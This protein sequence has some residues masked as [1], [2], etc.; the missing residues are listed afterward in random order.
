MTAVRRIREVAK[1]ALPRAV[2]ERLP[3]APPPEV[4]ELLHDKRFQRAVAEQAA[5]QGRPEEEVWSEV[6]GYLHE[7]SAA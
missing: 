1:T 7:M 6:K 5:E 2:G 3:A 4:T